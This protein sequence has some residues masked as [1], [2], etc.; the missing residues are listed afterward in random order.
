MFKSVHL[1]L[2]VAALATGYLMHNA[3]QPVPA[4][5]QDTPAPSHAHADESDTAAGPW[6]IV[7]LTLTVENTNP[8]HGGGSSVFHTAIRYNQITGET[9]NL[10]TE[11]DQF[12][13]EAIWRPTKAW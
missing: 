5:A 2:L 12:G 7:P 8:D 11:Y 1:S 9:Q 3:V 6:R 13:A 10:N 4:L